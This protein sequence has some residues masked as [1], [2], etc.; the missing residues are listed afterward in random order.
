MARHGQADRQNEFE[1]RV[2]RIVQRLYKGNK[3]TALTL[4]KSVHR[5]RRHNSAY[6]A[7]IAS[8]ISRKENRLLGRLLFLHL[9]IKFAVLYNCCEFRS[10]RQSRISL[11]R[12]FVCSAKGKAKSGIV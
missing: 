9:Y 4:R 1:L 7:T 6:C 2:S 8:I 5:R 10:I 3:Q 11:P 12:K